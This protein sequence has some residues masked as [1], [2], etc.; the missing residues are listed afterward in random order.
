M[1]IAETPNAAPLD[2]QAELSR[3][4]QKREELLKELG[5]VE[6]NIVK[7]RGTA[8]VSYVDP[9]EAEVVSARIFEENAELFKKLAQ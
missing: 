7:C 4:T 2:P 1:A 9:Q 3:L 5:Q 6:Q 8:S